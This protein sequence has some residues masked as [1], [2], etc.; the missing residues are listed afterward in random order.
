MRMLI[1]DT[2]SQACQS[3]KAL[4]DAGYQNSVVRQ[5]ANASEALHLLEEFL[6]EIILVDVRIPDSRGLRAI[7][8]I[9]A[10]FPSFLILVLSLD[11]KLKNKAISAGAD[12]F[13]S[14]SD[15]P[16][17]LLEAFTGALCQVEL[18]RGHLVRIP[19]GKNA[20]AAG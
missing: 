8:L 9:K 20:Y 6:P 19:N 14:K 2:R 4:L 10:E 16:E 1:I 11:T 15:P 17:R 18:K 3:R 13:I 12:A 7:R 5:A